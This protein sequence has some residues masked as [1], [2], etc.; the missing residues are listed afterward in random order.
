MSEMRRAD[1]TSALLLSVPVVRLG[2]LSHA[3][4]LLLLLLMMMILVA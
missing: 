3:V 1:P 4:L 2:G